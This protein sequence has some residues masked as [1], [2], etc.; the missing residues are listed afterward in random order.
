[1]RRYPKKIKLSAFLE[2]AD[3]QNYIH[4]KNQCCKASEAHC[5]IVIQYF[6]VFLRIHIRKVKTL[7]AFGNENK[8]QGKYFSTKENWGET[9]KLSLPTSTLVPTHFSCTNNQ[10][11]TQVLESIS[12][13]FDGS[14]L[15]QRLYCSPPSYIAEM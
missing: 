6:A 2:S 8:T 14:L 13:P 4:F 12:A 5:N 1:M 11:P 3:C 9:N 10:Q 15:Y 7:I